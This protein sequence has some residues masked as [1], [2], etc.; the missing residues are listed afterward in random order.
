[1]RV[2]LQACVCTTHVI[3]VCGDQKRAPDPLE[4]ELYMVLSYHVGAGNQTWALSMCSKS[5]SHLS[6]A[7][8]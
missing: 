8:T 7:L 2:F 3:S 4:V 5:L 6:S 1:M